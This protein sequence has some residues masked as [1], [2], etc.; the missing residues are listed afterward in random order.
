MDGGD[1]HHS[2]DG[3][4]LVVIGA[5]AGGIDALERLVGSLPEDFAAPIVIAQHS[6]PKGPG[7][8]AEILRRQT[9]LPVHIVSEEDDELRPRNVYIA[10]PG[11]NL[12]VKGWRLLSTPRER[13]HPVPSIDL[14]FTSAAEYAGDGVIAV[15][16]TGMG[17]DGVAGVRAVKEHGGTVVV[18]EL[19]S[20][21]YPALPAAIPQHYV[22]FTSNIE[23]LTSLL[24]TLVNRGDGLVASDPEALRAFLTQIRA[25]SGIDFRQYKEPTIR[26]RLARLMAAARTETL[27][28]YLRYLRTHEE[29]YQ[30]LISS[31]LIKVTGFFRDG[32]LF[33]YLRETVF[34]EIIAEA[35]ASGR[36]LRIWSAG[37][38]TGEEAY[39][40]AILLAELLGDALDEVRIRI[41]A[42]DLDIHAVAFARRGLYPASALSDVASEITSRYFTAVNGAH[43]VK[44]HIRNLTVFGE[45]D[46]GQRAPFPHIDLILCRNVLIYFTKELQQRVLQLFAFSLRVGGYLVLGKAE[47]TSPLPQFFTAAQ[48]TLKVYRRHG[49]RLLIPA[50]L[51]D[52]LTL[53]ERPTVRRAALRPPPQRRTTERQPGRWTL[54]DRLGSFVF[55]SSIGIVVVDANYDIQTINQ[56]ARV[57]LGIAG[58][59][60]GSDLVHISALPPAELKAALDAAFRGDTPAGFQ[61]VEI[62]DPA[63]GEKRYVELACYPERAA[64]KEGRVE[65]VIVVLL[66]TSKEARL[67][68]DLQHENQRNRSDL[69]RLSLQNKEL[70]ERQRSLMQANSEVNEANSELRNANEH[71]M[72]A[73]EEAEASAEEVETLNEELQATSE[74]LETLNEELQATVEEL[75]TTNEELGARSSELE[76]IVRDHQRQLDSASS[77][78]A[79]LRAVI[80]HMP[81]ALCLVDR[82]LKVISASR[83][84]LELA[85]RNRGILPLPGEQWRKVPGTV[86]VA[87]DGTSE[88]LE[89]NSVSLPDNDGETIL[90]FDHRKRAGSSSERP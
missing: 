43:Q 52:G 62:A 14:L 65:G 67:R 90:L 72:I 69:D 49:E 73:A 88:K 47:T 32:P 76:R 83:G 26:R 70:L 22:D 12:A 63:S 38:A 36:E 74:E 82:R 71:L 37:C 23:S 58:Q 35:R 5:S 7:R 8:F 54:V 10:A 75:N 9:R 29:A 48:P 41:F 44:K 87:N 61:E 30:Q 42:T 24:V 55:D 27:A 53:P 21:A 85:E 45:Y 1:R 3:S 20:A 56:T 86:N 28:D 18:Q 59:G 84:Y 31:F 17:T 89:V 34:P 25:R 39:S 40:L 11:R 19:E 51:V 80:E 81:M 4:Y 60:M 2:P 78:L 15:I 66:D 77:T 16:L 57:L 50:P 64:G 68:R 13:G 79:T 6:D 46:L 33:S